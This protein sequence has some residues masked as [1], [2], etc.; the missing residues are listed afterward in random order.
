MIAAQGSAQQPLAAEYRRGSGI[1]GS[2]RLGDETAEQRQDQ[3]ER[4]IFNGG[5][6][7]AESEGDNDRRRDRRRDGEEQDGGADRS[8]RQARILVFNF[9]VDWTPNSANF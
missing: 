8:R 6:N 5:D 3:M 7:D 9:C 2:L 1:T 4:E